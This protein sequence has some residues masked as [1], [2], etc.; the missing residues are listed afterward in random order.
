MI[1]TFWEGKMPEYVKLCLE[2]WKFP[3]TLLNYENLDKYTDIPNSHL[4]H[5]YTLPQVADVVRA[6]V[7]RDNGGYWLDTDTI[8]VTG[9]L[10][11]E[12]VIGYPERRDHHIGY[13]HTEKNSDMFVRWCKYQD[14]VIDELPEMKKWN[15]LGNAFTDNYVKSNLDI[16]IRS[17]DGFFPELKYSNGDSRYSSYQ[18]FY[19]H[20][21]YGVDAVKDS[22]LLML[23]NSWTPVDYK[24]LSRDEVLQ[25]D[26][27]MSNI[28]RGLL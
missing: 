9:K 16:T 6:H 13:L 26:C 8:S 2:T 19:F 24:K 5:R 28:L 12:N 25:S 20:T 11:E 1:F 4:L 15:I 27:T 17:V 23:H 10:P 22:D 14:Y 3:Y 7:L 21:N 18:N